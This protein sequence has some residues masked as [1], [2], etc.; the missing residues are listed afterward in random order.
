M[1]KTIILFFG[2]ILLLNGVDLNT[3]ENNESNKDGEY[4]F[5]LF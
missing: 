3:S 5:K 2:M 1:K 4:L